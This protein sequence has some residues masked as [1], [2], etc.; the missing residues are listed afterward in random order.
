MIYILMSAILFGMVHPGSKIILSSGIGLEL[1]C[2][3]YIGIRLLVQ[4]PFVIK[5]KSYRIENKGQLKI[6][7]LL[8]F[9]GA[10]LQLS[11]FAG[12][13]E[14]ADVSTVT[15]L[16]YTHP[17]WS[18]LISKLYFKENLGRTG[19]TKLLLA[20]FG[21]FFVIGIENFGIENLSRHWV[22]LVAGLLIAIW[23]KVSNVARKE[24]FSTL[25][26]NFYYDLTS[27]ACIFI[28]MLISPSGLEL[29]VL[30]DYLFTSNNFLIL[31][32]YSIFIGL[33]PNLLFYKGSS[34]TDSI[35]AGY[36]LLLE[37]II[38]SVIAYFSWGDKISMTFLVGALLILC[39]NIPNAFFLRAV[40]VAPHAV[41][42]LI[43][44]TSLTAFGETTTITKKIV[45]LEIIPSDSS[46][47]TVSSE[48]KQIE[49]AADLAFAEF[50]KN[51]KCK[52]KIEKSLE[53]GDEILLAQRVKEIQNDSSEKIIVGLSRTNFAR[54][55]AK[56]SVGSGLRGISVGASTS[57]LG[58]INKNFMTMVNP[59]EEQF[60]LVK[61]SLRGNKCL[62]SET[63]GLFN[64]GNFL[65]SNFMTA[66]KSLNLG[67]TLQDLKNMKW[68]SKIKCVFIG[69]NFA[70]ASGILATLKNS[71]WQG[72]IIGIGD[73][74]I[75]SG[76]LTKI[77]N[78]L[79]VG[80]NI[81]VPTG[82][83]PESSLNSAKFSAFF[84]SKT[85][86]IASPIAAYVYDGILL[87]SE[88]LCNGA[89]L[90][91]GVTNT[92]AM[93][94]SYKGRNDSGNLLSEMYLKSFEGVQ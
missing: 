56:V 4:I 52:I 66:Y 25:K 65:S 16:V 57:N 37:P 91:K 15:F 51:N 78:K 46:E 5:T 67:E 20:I 79:P 70:E 74:N 39:A 29:N 81:S 60:N 82:W 3:A 26:T 62:V 89:D 40:K 55:A 63:L 68:E 85:N 47:Y 34:T 50:K 11:E 87:A 13:A 7:L 54:V 80:V 41:L 90:Y 30:A 9:I 44:F 10:S 83:I 93:L 23:I 14:G 92:P 32:G 43:L 75:Y 77:T 2:F 49:V 42:I 18:I 45:L 59:W 8:G 1:F 53:L 94:R 71:K 22:S 12:I 64:S 24:G 69:L 76:E 17:F 48:K 86:E 73:W 28:L 21:I 72:K 31:G 27:F 35:T 58:D 36:I 61:E 6:I 33:L 19:M 84:K 38:A 88:S